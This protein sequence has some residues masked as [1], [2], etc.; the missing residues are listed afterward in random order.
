VAVN[1]KVGGSSPPSSAFLFIVTFFLFAN[2]FSLPILLQSLYLFCILFLFI[3]TYVFPFCK[4]LFLTNFIAIPIFISYSIII[5]RDVFSFCKLLFLTNFITIP[6]FIF[7]LAI[8]QLFITN[9]TYSILFQFP[10]FFNN[11][12]LIPIFITHNFY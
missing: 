5:Y 9:F 7:L 2:Y 6:I 10:H 12:F 3:V 8:F 1:H 11:S 4:L